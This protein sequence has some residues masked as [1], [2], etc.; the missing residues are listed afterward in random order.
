MCA[1]VSASYVQNPSEY[2]ADKMHD[3]LEKSLDDNALTRA[4]LARHE[5]TAAGPRTNL[6]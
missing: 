3:A 4:V 1:L 6:W 2:Y 5:V